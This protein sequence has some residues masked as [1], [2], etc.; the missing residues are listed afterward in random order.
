M[1]T[2][3]G[4]TLCLCL[5]YP[6]FSVNIKIYLES[7]MFFY[8]QIMG[9]K[10]FISKYFIIN[11]ESNYGCPRSLLSCHN[12]MVTF[13][14]QNSKTRKYLTK[15][16]P[17]VKFLWR[18]CQHILPRGFRRARDYGFLHHNSKQLILLI[19]FLCKINPGTWI[20]KIKKRVSMLCSCCGAPMVIVKTQIPANFY[21]DGSPPAWRK[22]K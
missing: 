8:L 12:G 16:L 21:P 7:F 20:A 14:Y 18:V 3:L 10:Y 6:Y 2:F 13:R 19:Q 4:M 15:T 9:G 5:N 17:A 1:S 11:W 22:I